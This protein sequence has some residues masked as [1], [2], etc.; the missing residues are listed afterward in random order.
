MYITFN[1]QVALLL[2]TGSKLLLGEKEWNE[3]HIRGGEGEQNVCLVINNGI[4]Y[5]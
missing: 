5:H 3:I 1:W 2:C 4:N